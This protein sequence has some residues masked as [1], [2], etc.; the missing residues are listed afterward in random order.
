MQ[1]TDVKNTTEHTCGIQKIT[2]QHTSYKLRIE[3]LDITAINRYNKKEKIFRT[4]EIQMSYNF[5]WSA[6]S[7]GAPIVTIASYGITFNNTVIELM[8]RPEKVLIGYDDDKKVVGV[9]PLGKDEVQNPRGFPFASRERSGY[10]RI[11]NKDFV[12]YLSKKNDVDYSR[13][14]R[15]FGD[16]DEDEQ[17]LVIDLNSPLDPSDVDDDEE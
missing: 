3:R 7:A 1:N 8:G 11:G 4:G 6:P 12:K 2:W 17:L 16:W 14:V 10:V 13:A 5:I 15:Y 9:K